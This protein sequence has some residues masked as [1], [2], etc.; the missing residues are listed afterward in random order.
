VKYRLVGFDIDGTLVGRD[1]AISARV[2]EATARMQAAGI[3]GCIVTGR[4]YRSALPFAHTLGFDAPLICYQG[5]WVVDPNDG[6]R[7]REVQLSPGAVSDLIARTKRDRMHLQLYKDDRYYCESDNR[8]AELYATVSSVPPIVVPSLVD[9]FAGLGATKGVVIADPGEAAA[10]ATTLETAF[11][12]RAYVTR[13]YPEFVEVL[14]AR[15]DKGAALR[16]VAERLQIPIE[17]T[18]AIGDA[19]NDAPLLRAAGFGI[20]MGSAPDELRA[21]ADAVVGDVSEDGVAQAVDEYI[22][23]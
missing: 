6:A 8:F 7:L 22:L 3:R 21:C 9:E 13:S 2:R 5:A 18:A 1:L 23:A 12:G 11:R 10:Y 19:W 4:M 14:D 15:V 20:A 17:E 16:Y